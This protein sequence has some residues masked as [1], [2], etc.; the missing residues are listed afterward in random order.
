MKKAKDIFYKLANCNQH[1]QFEQFLRDIIFDK[2]RRET[3]YASLID[4]GIYDTRVDIFKS[5][6]E[7]Y[8]AERKSNMQ[9]F[10][11]DK[12]AE[13]LAKIVNYEKGDCTGWAGYDAAAGTGTLIIKKWNDD[14]RSNTFASYR[15]SNYIYRCDEYADNVIP[16]LVHNLAFRGMNAIV[17]HGDTITREAKQVY[18]MCNE[19]DS[20]M[21]FSNVNVMPHSI[22]TERMFKIKFKADEP[23]IKHIEN[24]K[25]L[26]ARRCNDDSKV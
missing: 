12:V 2:K 10:T 4:E 21:S 26:F 24:K 15:P 13:L 11:P 22:D 3:F 19:D 23:E 7:A 8:S 6:F 1:V 9:D 18:F 16:Y 14:V 17:V 5:Y 20:Y 25:E